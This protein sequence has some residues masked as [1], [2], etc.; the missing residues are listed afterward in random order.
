MKT[1]NIIILA[2]VVTSMLS[3]GC[4][5]DSNSQESPEDTIEEYVLYYNGMQGD[6]IYN[7]LSTSQKERTS[8]DKVYNTILNFREEFK[9]YDYEIIDTEF[10]D[11]KATLNVDITWEISEVQFHKTKNYKV[12]FVLEDDKWKLDSGIIRI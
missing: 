9:I 11:N 7:L 12:D 8:K 5:G 4:T 10:S 6:K 2:I 1:Y 3:L